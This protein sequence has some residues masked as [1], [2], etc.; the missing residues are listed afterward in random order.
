VT[1]NA[2]NGLGGVLTGIG[3]CRCSK[4]NPSWTNVG[5]LIII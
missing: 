4:C 2:S 1:I 3:P 5:L